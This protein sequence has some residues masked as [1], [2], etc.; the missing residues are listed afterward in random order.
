MHTD[1]KIENEIGNE[2]AGYA[3]YVLA[4]LTLTYT[5]SYLD[6]YVLSVLIEPIKAD[7]HLSDTQLGLLGG[8]AFALL[9]TLAGIPI[10]RL[11]DR[12]NRRSIIALGLTAWS[13][14]TIACGLVRSFP[15]LLLARV[16]VG[17]GEA[18]CTPPAHSLIADY[19]PPEKRATALSIYGMG[20][21]VGVM[22][23]F[24]AGGWISHYFDWRTA[25]I[26]VGAPG[27]LLALLVRFTVREPERARLDT[28]SVDTSDYTLARALHFLVGHR[29]LILLQIGGAFFALAGFGLSFWIAPFFARVH[30][31]SL[32]ELA[33]GLAFG[34][35][36]GGVSGAW[37]SGKIAD[38]LGKKG[39]FW[40][41]MTPVF[42]LLVGVPMTLLMLNV[43]SYKMALALF[44]L[45]QFVFSAY[46]GP[47]YA[48]MQF[49]VPAKMRALIVAIHLF[50]L[51]LIGVGLGPLLIGMMNDA[52]LMDYGEAAAIR[53]SLMIITLSS[54]VTIVVL[55]WAAIC[56]KRQTIKSVGAE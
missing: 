22:L 39:L 19:F 16:G 45:Q 1:P 2:S 13:A 20:I 37:C 11:A 49:M 23:G 14:M 48:A 40:Y 56:V 28:D 42:A 47:I 38:Y 21:P 33:T 30:G 51:N 15:Q 17:L 6:R 26:V 4:V 18:A 53:Y 52:F 43:E 36:F 12:G 3:R 9:Y 27:I 44:I 55:T 7:L 10:A 54:L 31:L 24:L 5:C 25:F 35:F 34:A 29:P 41:I 50:I 8:L 46:S 32:Q